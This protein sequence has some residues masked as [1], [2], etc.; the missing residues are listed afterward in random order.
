[1]RDRF[2]GEEVWRTLGLPKEAADHVETSELQRTFRGYL[3]Y[4]IVPILKDIGLFGDKIQKAFAEMG[5]L[6]FADADIDAAMAEDEHI[7]EEIDERLAHVEA[8]AAVADR[9]RVRAAADLRSVSP[10]RRAL[11]SAPSS[12]ASVRGG[13]AT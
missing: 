12:S 3:F 11:A 5:V 9:G 2:L 6:S 10:L 13:S 8:T 7:A 4:R 1:M